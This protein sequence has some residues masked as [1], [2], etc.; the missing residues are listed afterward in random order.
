MFRFLLGCLGRLGS[1][2]LLC[3]LPLCLPAFR[4][5]CLP[6]GKLLASGLLLLNPSAL[7]LLPCPLVCLHL[8]FQ[9]AQALFLCH[10]LR[11]VQG[12]QINIL[13]VGLIVRTHFINGLEVCL[14]LF[15]LALDVCYGFRKGECGIEVPGV[16]QPLKRNYLLQFS[17]CCRIRLP[18]FLL[19]LLLLLVLIVLDLRVDDAYRF[20]NE[21]QDAFQLLLKYRV[22]LIDY[23]FHNLPPVLNGGFQLIQLGAV[24]LCCLDGIVRVGDALVLCHLFLD[25]R[26]QLGAVPFDTL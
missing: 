9:I 16:E 26:L 12:F 19:F 3:S 21:R 11:Q 18:D 20:V 8:L 1:C 2:P 25:C 6:P 14:N 23:L 10:R 22:R 5:L 24:C 17:D 4:L 7:C 15:N 13:G